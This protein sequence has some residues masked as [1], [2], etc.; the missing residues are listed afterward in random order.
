MTT[1]AAQ[2]I[3][4]TLHLFGI[5]DQTEDPTPDDIA[6]NVIVLNDMLR[7][8][9]MDAAAQY[10]MGMATAQ[11]PAGVSGQIYTFKV[12]TGQIVGVDAVGIKAMWANDVSLT[13]NRETRQAPKADVVRTTF[14]SIITKWH[15]ERQV[16]GSILV[17]AWQP[18]RAVTPI[19][20][21]Y[22]GRIP[23][24]TQPMGTD[25]VML[26]PEGLHDAKLMLG[27]TIC[28]SYG[29]SVAQSNPE[30]FQRAQ[31]TELRWREW[32]RGQQWMRF[33]RA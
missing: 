13:V 11:L 30:L 15:Q 29:R 16:D 10:L 17:T 26:P 32:A 1:T 33:V 27:L 5:T 21:E 6:S 2:L 14:P 24:L 7:S 9:H 18:P 12:G 22:G 19:L 3:A 4:D 20:I 31:R 25:V 28:A 8:E 23:A